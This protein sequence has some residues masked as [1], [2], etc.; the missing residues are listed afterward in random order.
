MGLT[1]ADVEVRE[2][3]GGGP[4]YAAWFLVDSGAVESLAPE[5]QLRAIGIEPEGEDLYELA[6]GSEVRLRHGFCRLR[7]MGLETVSKIIF[8]QPDKEPLL[9]AIALESLG[10]VVDPRT[11][12]IK[13]LKHKPLK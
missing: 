7:L 13:Q 5:D 2:L 9:G 8:G 11:Q 6:D 1:Y 12:M 3:A 4:G 10:L